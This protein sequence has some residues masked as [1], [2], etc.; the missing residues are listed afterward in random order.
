[1]APENRTPEPTDDTSAGQ[2]P[3]EAVPAVSPEDLA[4]IAEEASRQEDS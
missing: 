3:G 4:R 1:M 2:A